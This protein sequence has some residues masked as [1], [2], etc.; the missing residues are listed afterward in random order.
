MYNEA[1]DRLEAAINSKKGSVIQHDENFK[2]DLY[3]Y[4]AN[5]LDRQ[6]IYVDQD[7]ILLREAVKAWNYYSEYASCDKNAGDKD[8]IFAQ[9][10]LKELEKIDKKMSK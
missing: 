3:Y 9:K 1:R 2:K 4:Y 6:Y 5:S 7:P 8:C 10:R